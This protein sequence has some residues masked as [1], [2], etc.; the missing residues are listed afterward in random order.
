M[1]NTNIKRSAAYKVRRS[2]NSDVVTI[3][4]MIKEK[5][6]IEEGDSLA[7]IVNESGSITIEKELPKVNVDKAMEKALNQYHDLLSDLVDL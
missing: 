4:A 1:I 7:Y 5:L 2:G 3:P 6:G